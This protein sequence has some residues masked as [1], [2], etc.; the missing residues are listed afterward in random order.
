ML[1][2][3]ARHVAGG[4]RR[5]HTSLTVLTVHILS[6]CLAQIFVPRTEQVTWSSLSVSVALSLSP[7]PPSL[8][9]SI[10]LSAS[11]RLGVAAVCG[12]VVD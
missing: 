9:P 1:R 7:T 3:F 10:C 4:S 6:V 12:C 5:V 2:R 8:P 11:L